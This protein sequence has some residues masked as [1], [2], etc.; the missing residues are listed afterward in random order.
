MK[1]VAADT[2]SHRGAWKKGGK[3]W[4]RLITSQSDGI[5]R[6][7]DTLEDEELTSVDNWNDEYGNNNL[8][9]KV[10]SIRF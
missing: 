5:H 1:L 4:E 8:K 2:P 9:I 3:A 7:K 6:D 10:P